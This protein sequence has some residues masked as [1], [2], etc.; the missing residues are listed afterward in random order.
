MMYSSNSMIHDLE[1]SPCIESAGYKWVKNVFRFRK[2]IF[3]SF[4]VVKYL[5]LEMENIKFPLDFHR[6]WRNFVFI[7]AMI[8]NI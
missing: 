8:E 4:L 6:D 2:S 1:M 7:S 5:L 3:L